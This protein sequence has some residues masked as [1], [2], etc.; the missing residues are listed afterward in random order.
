MDGDYSDYPEELSKVGEKPIVERYYQN[1]VNWEPNK[2][3]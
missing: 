3:V 2:G 1:F